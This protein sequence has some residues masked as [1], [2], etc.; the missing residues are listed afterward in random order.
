MFSAT[1]K[2]FLT[3]SRSVVS[4]AHKINPTPSAFASV[5]RTAQRGFSQ[6][7]F[8][9]GANAN[10]VDQMYSQWRAD[11]SSVHASW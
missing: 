6:D 4:K 3:F 8:L 5:V 9:N 1:T 7:N 11:P 2:Q 10:Y